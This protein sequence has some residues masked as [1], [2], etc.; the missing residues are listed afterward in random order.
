VQAR[1]RDSLQRLTAG[2]ADAAWMFFRLGRAPAPSVVTG[3]PPLERFV[4]L[5]AHTPA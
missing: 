3:R 1:L 2:Q 4:H 5:S